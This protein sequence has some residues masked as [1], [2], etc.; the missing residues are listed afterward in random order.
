MR[1]D[2]MILKIGLVLNISLILSINC[3][4]KSDDILKWV[5]II[6]FVKLFG[7]NYIL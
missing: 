2:K 5:E 6:T 7:S 3:R 4:Y 1:Y